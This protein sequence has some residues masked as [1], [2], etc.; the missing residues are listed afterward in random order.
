MSE[1][2]ATVALPYPPEFFKDAD[3]GYG[4][5][6]VGCYALLAYLASVS[7]RRYHRILE[8]GT[9]NGVGTPDC[10]V[11]TVENVDDPIQTARQI[12]LWER[13]GVATRTV[14]HVGDSREVLP[15]LP[16]HFDLALIDASHV[17]GIKA[18]D[19]ASVKDRALV[20]V[21]DDFV[22]D[23]PFWQEAAVNPGWRIAPTTAPYL[24]NESGMPD[25]RGVRAATRACFPSGVS[26]AWNDP[27][28]SGCLTQPRGFAG[29]RPGRFPP[30]VTRSWA[31][32][33]RWNRSQKSGWTCSSPKGCAACN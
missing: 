8:V 22:I 32:L 2:V 1:P 19:W 6:T 11:D 33:R 24:D 25:W 10:I 28:F 21:F 23:W 13:R 17:W 29:L 5:S 16:G 26:Q 14:R 12:A 7:P 3:C 9:H 20:I 4:G 30:R 18:A 31:S 27:C 15:S